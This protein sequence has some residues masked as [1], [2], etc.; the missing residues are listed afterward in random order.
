M[1]I[2]IHTPQGTWYVRD[3]PSSVQAGS[4]AEE[5]DTDRAKR[6]RSR[7][8][9]AG[10]ATPSKPSL[11]NGTSYAAGAGGIALTRSHCLSAASE[12]EG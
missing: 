3:V 9:G 2:H 10:R 6:V 7:K 5:R 12:A 11:K 4:A 1:K 8:P